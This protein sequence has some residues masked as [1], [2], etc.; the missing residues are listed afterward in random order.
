MSRILLASE[1]VQNVTKRKPKRKFREK[2]EFTC[3]SDPVETE[4]FI[5][6]CRNGECH[7]KKKNLDKEHYIRTHPQRDTLSWLRDD[8]CTLQEVDFYDREGSI[9]NGKQTGKCLNYINLKTEN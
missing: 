3:L 7:P 5:E 2:I 4:K 1:N 6:K 8:P 9:F